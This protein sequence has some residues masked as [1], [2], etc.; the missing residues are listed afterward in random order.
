MGK[1]LTKE[2]FIL[3]LSQKCA[4]AIEIIE[5][6]GSTKPLKAKIKKTGEI[7]IWPNAGE[8]Y[9][10]KT[11]TFKPPRQ[12]SNKLSTTD[13]QSRLDLNYGKNN[14][15][16]LEFNSM[17]AP[18]KIQC[19]K[20]KT[21]KNFA[22]GKHIERKLNICDCSK[23]NL[24][25]SYYQNELDQLFGKDEFTIIKFEKSYKPLTLKHK[26]GFIC[27]KRDT[28]KMRNMLGC[29]ICEKAKSKGERDIANFLL[30]NKIPFVTEYSFK[31]LRGKKYPLRFDF[32]IENNNK[33]LLIEFDGEG[34]YLDSSLYNSDNDNDKRKD[35][36]CLAHNIPLLRIPYWEYKKINTLILN[37][38][39]FNDYPLG[40]QKSSDFE[41]LN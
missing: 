2:E 39:R 18:V 30:K 13:F 4:E 40:E 25:K 10:N 28:V 23:N 41:T 26:C 19:L 35:E 8:L 9:R 15:K 36:Y 24:D 22:S 38:L 1:K 11:G 12:A 27:T 34:H 20:C 31:D 3:N 17:S 32:M 6:N 21:I 37:F 33:I 7:R 14:F 16:V 5:F 29:P